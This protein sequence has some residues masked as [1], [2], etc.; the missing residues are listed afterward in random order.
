MD[1]P[2][3]HISPRRTFL[4]QVGALTAMA[5]LGIGEEAEANPIPMVI[6]IEA[7]K[8]FFKISLGEWSFHKQLQAG[9][10]NNLDFPAKAKNEFGVDAVEYVNVFF[11]DK[12]KNQSYLTELRNRCK[13]V[14]V[15][16]R[17]ILC[18]GLGDLADTDPGQRTKSIENHFPWVDAAHFLGCDSIRVNCAGKGT[19]AEVASAGIDGLNRLS[20]YASKAKLNVLVENHGGFSSNAKWTASVIRSVNKRNCGTLPDFDNFDISETNWYDRYQGVTELM[21]FAKYVSA[22]TVDFDAEGNCTETD[23][24]R[25]LTIVKAAGYRGY[26]G[27]EYEGDKFS[28]EEGVKATL[29]LLR[30]VGEQLN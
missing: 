10:L 13:D 19:E 18:D 28:E 26:L 29:R 8:L 30:K 9:T 23:Y 4:K 15:S 1:S 5:A 20:E 14:G 7:K 6:G 2:F 3:D 22:K 17:I 21:P 11:M 27:A 12:A 25:M 24:V 16:S